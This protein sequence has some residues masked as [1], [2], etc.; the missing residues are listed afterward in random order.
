MG[1]GHHP[2]DSELSGS[3]VSNALKVL[4]YTCIDYTNV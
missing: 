3:V 4:L 1:H 2:L